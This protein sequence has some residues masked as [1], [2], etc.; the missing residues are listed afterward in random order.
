MVPADNARTIGSVEKDVIYIACTREDLVDLAIEA[1]D[2]GFKAAD[3]DGAHAATALAQIEERARAA[4]DAA[5]TDYVPL[6]MPRFC[7]VFTL[8][9]VGGYSARC[10]RASR[11]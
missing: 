5:L 10:R 6:D 9:W 7:D 2:L 11:Q 8:A 3:V 1:W 4:C